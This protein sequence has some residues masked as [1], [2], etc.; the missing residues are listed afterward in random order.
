MYPDCGVQ[1]LYSYKML[2]AQNRK[3]HMISNC[4]EEESP[5]AA[6]SQDSS[7]CTARALT[8]LLKA[9]F[10]TL[11][12]PN[13]GLY[14]KKHCLNSLPANICKYAVTVRRWHYR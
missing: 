3:K 11:E 10:L 13:S 14:V 12:A 8:V 9:A 2:E 7:S 1:R 5:K 4:S 6:I